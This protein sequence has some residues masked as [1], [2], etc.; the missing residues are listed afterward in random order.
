MITLEGDTLVFRFPEVHED[1]ECRVEFQRTL[2]IPNNGHDYPLPPGLG[3]FPLRHLDDYADN[4][5]PAWS[6]RGGVIMPMRQA[7]AMWVNYKQCG[8]YPFAVK[9]AAGKINAVT[10]ESWINGLNSDPQDYMVVPDQPWLDGYCVEKGTIRQFVAAPMGEGHTAEEQLTGASVHGGIQIIA[11]PMKVER[12]ERLARRRAVYCRMSVLE[13]EFAGASPSMGLAPGGRMKQEIYD[14]H[15]GL[16]AWD[17]RHSSR[18][19]VT[20]A[21]AAVWQAITGERPPGEPPTVAEYDKAGLPWFDFYDSDREALTGSKLLAGLKSYLEDAFRT[22]NAGSESPPH[23]VGKI[24][25]LK[26]QRPREV[27][28]ATM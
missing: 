9:V 18:C 27:R 11:Y 16:D 25:R 23:P 22:R 26:D 4:L 28:E 12:Y 6:S 14:D 19:F 20:I 10:G 7:E 2:R 13:E 1:A 8:E 21:N 24:V 5:P 15:H 17:Q 3:S